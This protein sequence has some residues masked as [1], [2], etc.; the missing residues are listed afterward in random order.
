MQK[1]YFLTIEFWAKDISKNLNCDGKFYSEIGHS[2]KTNCT[3]QT[4]HGL[5]LCCQEWNMVIGLPPVYDSSAFAYSS[6]RKCTGS[7]WSPGPLFHIKMFSCQYRKSHC[8]DKTV[9]RSSYLHNG[10][11][12]TGKTASFFLLNRDLGVHFGTKMSSH[13]YGIFFVQKGFHITG[14][15]RTHA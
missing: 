5:H 10:I 1:L 11:S 14:V 8:G 6:I 2:T 9:I 13:Q 15:K 7:F 4:G 3:K 12:Y